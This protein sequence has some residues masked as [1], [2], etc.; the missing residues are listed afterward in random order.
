MKDNDKRLIEQGFPCHQVGAE[1]RRERGASSAL[2]PL[3]FLHVWWARRPLTPSR[4]A[5]LASLLPA[6]TDP[7]TFIRSLGIEKVQTV[8]KGVPCTL[9]GKIL[10]KIRCSESAKEELS[11]DNDVIQFLKNED[12]QRA[13]SRKRIE[14]LKAEDPELS[15]DP[16]FLQWE[17][18]SRPLPSPLPEQGETLPVQ[19]VSGDPAWFK[20]LM[21]ICEKFN[22]RLPNLYGYERA[23]A[24]SQPPVFSDITVLDPTSGGGSIPFEALRLGYN[25]I[26][27]DLN[28]VAAVILYATLEYP[29]RF[30]IKLVHDIENWGKQLLAYAEKE[31]EGLVHFSPL[32]DDERNRLREF[33]GSCPEIFPQFDVPEYDHAGHIF[34]RQ[35]TCPHCRGEAPLLNTCWLSKEAKNAWAVRLVSN[36]KSR[37]A[38]VSFETYPVKKGRGPDGEDPNFGTVKQGVGFCIHCKQA[39]SGNEI[40]TQARGDSPLGTWKDRLYCIAARRIDPVLDKFGKPECL[41]SGKRK[42]E[43]KIRKLRFFRPPNKADLKALADAE[44]RLAEKWDAWE[45]QGL[46]PTEK[47]P[48]GSDNRPVTYG[49]KRWCDMFTPRQLLGHLSLIQGLNQLSPR[50]IQ[51]LGPEKGRAVITYLQFA[52]DKGADY[53]SKQ[54]RWIPQRGIVSGTFSRHDFS[55]KWT[56]G[57]MI[58]TGPNSGAAWGLSQIID[59]YKGIAGL[60]APVYSQIRAGK[61]LPLKIC[62][63]TAAHLPEVADKSVDLVCMDPPY[64]DNVQYAELSDFFYVWQKRTLKDL[65]PDIFSRRLTNKKDEAVANP[66]REGSAKDAKSVYEKRMGEIFAECRRVLKDTGILTLMF[67]HKSQDAWE[68]LTR[69]LIESGWIITATVPVESEFANSMHQLNMAAAASSIFISC[70]KREAAERFP[71]VWTGIGGAGV[72]RRI[73]QAVEDGLKDYEPLQLSPVDQM[74]ACYGRSLRVLSEHW[75]VMDGDEAVSPV[76]AMNEA[77]RVVSEYQIRRVTGNRLTVDELDSESAMVLTLFGIWGLNEFSFNDA[78]NLSKSM[79]IPIAS[80]PGGYR[81]EA[82]MVAMNRLDAGRR[83][84]GPGEEISGFHAPLVCKGSAVRIARPEERNPSRLADPQ[85]LWDIVQG[86]ILEYRKGDIPLARPYLETHAPNAKPLI[87]DILRVWETETR[88]PELKKEAENLLFSLA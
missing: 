63:G 9:T 21:G 1:T 13:D 38:K 67:T 17:S 14:T 72:Q 44:K 81:V 27:N 51:E 24:N 73:R 40:R 30:G 5:I 58:F 56:F 31:M 33:L 65:Y 79:N 57:E 87:L 11:V 54:T 25:V 2:P 69:S 7:E 4:A 46:I 41:K 42:G 82:R 28:P 18:E 36:G 12:A 20:R 19:R 78:L 43:I 84:R 35:V 61:K 70:R 59:A 71:A 45:L 22:L 8:V 77:S 83:S 64:Y 55:L 3:Y 66:A 23:F 74:V 10:K 85:T 47:F 60:V 62:H 32:P 76:R 50:I 6:D 68:T 29:A 86:L 80:K 37:N 75:P 53:N 39:I 15:K 26:A 34:C 16:V 49:M 88:D 52:I 48:K